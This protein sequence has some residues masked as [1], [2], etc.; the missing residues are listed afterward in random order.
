MDP[1]ANLLK[2][3]E[4][5]GSVPFTSVSK[6][7]LE[8]LKG[9]MDTGVFE[10]VHVGNGKRIEVKS[11]V[12]FQKHIAKMFPQG[13]A[14][15]VADTQDRVRSTAVHRD[16]KKGANKVESEGVIFRVFSDKATLVAINGQYLC[17]RAWC[18]LAG[19][20][21]VRIKEGDVLSVS[22]SA[23]TV[24]NAEVFWRFEE[25][26]IEVDIIFWTA[27]KI[28]NRFL[29]CLDIVNDGFLTHFGD[30]DPVGVDEYLRIKESIGS[31]SLYVPENIEALFETYGKESLVMKNHKIYERLREV[32]DPQA[33]RIVDLMSRY[34]CGV[35]HEALII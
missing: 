16:S 12:Y 31:V 9:L 26:G 29:D 32:K 21:A 28:S 10:I 8:R 23:A 18:D 2:K 7:N 20:A 1:Y 13:L 24:E 5:S 30:Y 35:E 11:E 27:G 6:K 33:R 14:S 22:G 19:C 4:V 17:A 3:I 15:A 25:L 34:N